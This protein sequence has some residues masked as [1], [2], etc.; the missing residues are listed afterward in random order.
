MERVASTVKKYYPVLNV[1]AKKSVF[2]KKSRRWSACLFPDGWDYDRP[3]FFFAHLPYDALLNRNFSSAFYQ[4]K[5][6]S[7]RE[8]TD[9]QG[10]P[11]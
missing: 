8:G 6:Y 4:D 11:G 2:I 1:Y 5:I 10:G 3:F 9:I 7:R